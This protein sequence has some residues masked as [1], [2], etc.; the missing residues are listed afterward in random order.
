MGSIM[1]R[2]LLVM[3]ML[4]MVLVTLSTCFGVVWAQSLEPTSLFEPGQYGVGLRSF[5]FVDESR[6][7]RT[8][9][10]FVWFPADKNDPN[11]NR[12]SE[13]SLVLANSTPDKSGGPYPLL[14]YSHGSP[15]SSS[16][17]RDMVEHLVSRG[18][19]VAA[20][21]HI[22]TVP[23]RLELVD[24]PLDVLLVLNQLA[25]MNDGELA[26]VIDTNNVGVMGFSMGAI[27]TS[28]L[29]GME[30][31][32]VHYT[33]WCAEHPEVETLDCDPP[34]SEIIWDFDA[35]AAYRT[36]LGLEDL[37]DGTWAPF[38]DERIRAAMMMAPCIFPLTTEEM[39]TDVKIPTLVLHGVTDA[40]CDYQGN[41]VRIFDHLGTDERYLF[42]II[43][44]DHNSFITHTEVQWYFAVAFFSYYLGGDDTYAPYLK[45]D[46]FSFF[47]RFGSFKVVSGA[48]K[49]G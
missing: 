38:T 16:E 47:D 33:T 46:D 12:L 1:L 39:I 19:V 35:I 13:S 34:P 26:G 44:G 4:G 15:G 5:K 10:T 11:A 6:G 48:Y 28:E 40:T 24:R 9:Q 29:I 42:S 14:I 23:I 49:G 17:M 27:N 20:A 31:D 7:N 41:A 36:T 32:P 45:L 3:T 25:G 2:R 18:F 43:N 8:L 22:D 37:S 30:R 21:Q